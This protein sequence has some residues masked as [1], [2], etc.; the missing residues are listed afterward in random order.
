MYII[1]THL[2]FLT[3]E[4]NFIAVGIIHS[5]CFLTANSLVHT[6]ITEVVNTGAFIV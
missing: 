4:G 3:E 2:M 1:H 6:C 5:Q